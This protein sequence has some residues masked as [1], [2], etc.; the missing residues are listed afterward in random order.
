[1]K[2]NALTRGRHARLFVTINLDSC[3]LIMII[4]GLIDKELVELTSLRLLL[5]GVQSAANNVLVSILLFSRTTYRLFREVGGS[6][7]RF[8]PHFPMQIIKIRQI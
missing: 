3:Q 6:A 8:P 1:M 2:L 4:L 7:K 5:L